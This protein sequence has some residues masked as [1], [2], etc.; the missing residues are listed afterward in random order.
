ML[1]ISVMRKLLVAAL[2]PPPLGVRLW[3]TLLSLMLGALK[4]AYLAEV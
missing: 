2:I 3:L 1:I 4:L